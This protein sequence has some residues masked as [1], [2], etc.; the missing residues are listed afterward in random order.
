MSFFNKQMKK[1][2]AKQNKL[3]AARDNLCIPLAQKVI[4][5]IADAN[6]SLKDKDHSEYIKEYEPLVLK[7]LGLYLESD[8]KLIDITYINKLILEMVGKVDALIVHSIN[9]SLRIGEKAVWGV[10]KDEMTLG[11]LDEVLKKW[12][13]EQSIQQQLDD[14]RLKIQ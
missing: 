11:K 1:E 9:D 5:M 14:N 4:K 10:N 7:I 2:V 6:L 12:A 8:L 3:D 13:E